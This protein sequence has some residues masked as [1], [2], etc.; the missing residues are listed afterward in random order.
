MFL[1]K[2]VFWLTAAEIIYSASGYIIHAGVGRI[3]GPEDY[4]RYGLVVTL[5][6]MIIMLIGWGIPSAMSKFLSEISETKPELVYIIKKQ[7]IL[8]QIILIGVLTVVFFFLSPVIA[9]A[10]NDRT[11]TPLFRLSSLIIPSFAAASFYFYY[12]TGLHR[13]NIQSA[14][15]VVRSLARVVIIIILAYFFRIEGTI[16]GYILA[17]LIVFFAGWAIDRGW[18]SKKYPTTKDAHFDWKKLLNYAWPITLFMLFYEFLISLD[19]YF[20]K[21]LLNSDFLTGVYNGSLTVG[22][23]PYYLFYSLSIVLLPTISKSTSQNNNKETTKIINQSL[24][25]MVMLLLPVVVLMFVYAEPIVDLF[26]GAG[27]SEAAAPMR[28]LIFGVGF[29]TVFYVMSFVFNGAG[30]VKIPMYISFFGMSLNAVLNYILIQ[31]YGIMGS[32]VATSISSALIMLVMLF[33]I[34]KHFRGLFRF[35]G[36]LKMLLATFVIFLLSRFFPAQNPLFLVWSAIL[37]AAYFFT[38]YLF[39]EIKKED[40]NLLK[41]LASRSK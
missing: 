39:G 20:V 34:H 19:L 4:G 40:T 23:I 41:K 28:V 26:Y 11:L 6:T 1:A 29:L 17:P 31:K 30:L 7:T 15:K 3:L 8:L 2:S 33:Y 38:L 37:F 32:A 21:A 24:R 9:W 27:Y 16:L 35:S 25:F 18:I 12:Y 22:R 5:T 10:L 14:L 13:F 36:F